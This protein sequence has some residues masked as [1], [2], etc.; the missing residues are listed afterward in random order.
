MKK[1]TDEFVHELA[2]ELNLKFC[3]IE[4]VMLTKDNYCTI[5]FFTTQLKLKVG[6]DTVQ[7]V[8]AKIDEKNTNGEEETEGNY[9]CLLF[10][11]SSPFK[12]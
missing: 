3:D 6:I 1:I 9:N 11:D 2:D 4:S 12:K 5:K 7:Q 10:N 8:F